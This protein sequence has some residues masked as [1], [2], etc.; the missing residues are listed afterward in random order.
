VRTF[1][2]AAKS[3]EG[4]SEQSWLDSSEQALNITAQIKK[5]WVKPRDAHTPIVKLPGSANRDNNYSVAADP[6]RLA[7]RKLEQDIPKIRLVQALEEVRRNGDVSG[8]HLD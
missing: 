6:R 7:L 1:G 3:D 4:G 5:G 2:S 8:P